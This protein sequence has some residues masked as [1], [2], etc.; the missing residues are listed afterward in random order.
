MSLSLGAAAP[1]FE[2]GAD[3]GSVFSLS[4]HRGKRV[5]LVFYPGDDTPVCSAQLCE[6]RDGLEEFEGLNVEVVGIGHQ[7]AES[8]RKFKQKRGLPFPLL[9][10]ANLKVAAQYGAKGLMGMK[11]ACF[12]IDEQGLLR[13]QH[14]EVTALFRRSKDELVQAIKALD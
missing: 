14:V 2:L 13:Y 5:L 10:D 4:E 6:Y 1:E 12:L 8:H 9:T 3:D 7:S 11:R